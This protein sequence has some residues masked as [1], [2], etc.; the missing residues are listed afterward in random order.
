[1][2]NINLN[3]QEDTKSDWMKVVKRHKRKQKGLPALSNLNTDAG[4]VEHNINMFNMM[5]PDGS[6]G[7]DASSGNTT[8]GASNCCESV[9]NNNSLNTT[10]TLEYENLPIEYETRGNGYFDSAFGN[11][12]PDYDTVE[13]TVD[14]TYE[15]DPVSVFEFL[16]DDPDVQLELGY[17]HLTDEQFTRK[18]EDM[19]SALVQ[20][21]KEKIL[22]YFY[23]D[24]IEDAQRKFYESVQHSDADLTN[25]TLKEAKLDD[26]FD[27]SMRTLL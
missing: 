3:I 26:N 21:H 23:D 7:V 8:S 18:L 4:N 13:T 11:Y 27:M 10:V 20:E 9:D 17:D 15:A 2:N 16:Q 12:L 1:M 5:Q 22:D 14:W 6:V 25:R 24:A 19:F